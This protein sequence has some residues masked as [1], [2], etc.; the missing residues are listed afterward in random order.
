LLCAGVLVA[1]A[2]PLSACKEVEE[3]TAAGYEPAKLASV[4][5]G[6]D[7]QRVT[8][9]EEGARRVGLQTA[10]VKRSG[11][12]KVVP[13]AALIY[14]AGGKTYVYTSPARLTYLRE[15]VWV[16]HAE[17]KRVFLTRGPRAGTDVVT[18]GAT[19]VYGTEFEVG[20]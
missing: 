4:K 14:E 16:D 1:V 6:D 9:T 10:P 17:G 8:F 12:Q 7:V 19:E 2:L 5:G 18:V 11:K 15:R 3:E 20:H 13:Y